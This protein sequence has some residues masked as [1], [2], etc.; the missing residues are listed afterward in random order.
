MKIHSFLIGVVFVLGLL[1]GL[2]SAQTNASVPDAIR[3]SQG[4]VFEIT[5]DSPSPSSEFN[6]IL[7][8]D[9]AFQSAAR[10]RFF[11]ARLTE[12]GTYV[13]DVSIQD[14]VTNQ[15]HYRAFTII[16]A[17]TAAVLPQAR[18][19]DSPPQARL[20]LQNPQGTSSGLPEQGGL[21]KID[22]SASTGR[23]D[24]FSLDLDTTLDSNGDGNPTNDDD[25]V[26]TSF[27][28]IGSPIFVAML[29]RPGRSVSLT[30]TNTRGDQPYTLALP[31]LYGVTVT[32]ST[33]GTVQ[34]AG[35]ISVKNDKGQ[36][37]FSVTLDQ[38]QSEGRQLL[39]EWD[40][41]DRVKSLLTSPT[42]EYRSAGTYAVSVRI[43]DIRTGEELFQSSQSVVVETSS[44]TG[45]TTSSS[46]SSDDI[47]TTPTSGGSSSIFGIIK[48]LLIIFVLLA[49]AIGLYALLQWIK[50]KTTTGI[51]KTLEKMEGAIVEKKEE[52]TVAKPAAVTIRPSTEA[53]ESVKKGTVLTEEEVIQK[54][55]SHTELKPT[56][57][58]AAPTT[59]AGPVPDWLKKAPASDQ[60]VAAPQK[61]TVVSTA[62]LTKNEVKTNV[63][64]PPVVTATEASAVVQNPTKQA[65]NGAVP[66]W[67]KP[68]QNT[69][70]PPKT[71]PVT[72]LAPPAPT[73]TPA[74][75]T[76]PIPPSP[77][78]EASPRPL[79]AA[80]QVTA[81]PVSAPLPPPAPKAVPP[82]VQ[83]RPAEPKPVTPST[84]QPIPEQKKDD[85][86]PPIAIISAD[87]LRK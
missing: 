37:T 73:A 85:T 51:Q 9:R 57:A 15:Q 56:A 4:E 76:P 30:V 68:K 18:N 75:V 87:S 52:E 35:P 53:S 58:S 69:P 40:F 71:E 36:L 80:P 54:E 81:K 34:Q 26:G 70:V 38:A 42:H 11:Q 43:R 17:E 31:V 74:P 24:R 1:P 65:D 63:P 83:N 77:K 12:P 55:M 47:V 78:V 61:A 33:S 62:P 10:T 64:K 25:T 84:S 86:D 27:E 14:S 82:A 8:K 39:Y 7:T 3:L 50:S 5:V 45:G 60:K 20:E 49:L 19:A 2:M 46:A 79:P 21:L 41:G 48:V 6:W 28:K 44:T 32:P 16:V 67:L 23:I 29:P 13:L 66:D 22:P 59:A 72:Q